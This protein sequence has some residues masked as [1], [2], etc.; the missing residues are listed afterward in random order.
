MSSGKLHSYFYQKIRIDGDCWKWTGA[1][2]TNGYGSFFNGIKTVRAHRYSFEIF[3]G[4][5]PKKK[6]I[7]HLCN[8]KKCVN[9]F[10]LLHGS[11]LE[12]VEAAIREGIFVPTARKSTPRKKVC[13]YGHD[14]TKAGSLYQYP[15]PAKGRVCMECRKINSIRYSAEYRERRKFM[16]KKKAKSKV[17]KKKPA[18]KKK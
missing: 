12:N 4:S 2:S 10:H 1:I 7:M 17:A 5:I 9:P 14:L 13:K 6:V 15:N 18:T 3:I 11:Q 16:A 8:N